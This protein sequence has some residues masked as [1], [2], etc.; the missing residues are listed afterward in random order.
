MGVTFETEVEPA[1]FSF[2]DPFHVF[3][4]HKV[5]SERVH[6]CDAHMQL[7]GYPQLRRILGERKK[8]K[9][10]EGRHKKEFDAC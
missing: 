1:P 3:V 2:S 6:L 7:F 5:R 10:Q 4:C 9:R 8:E